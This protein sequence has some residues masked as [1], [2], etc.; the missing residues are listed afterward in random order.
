MGSGSGTRCR[1]LPVFLNLMDVIYRRLS[2]D[3]IKTL[4][5]LKNL[6]NGSQM[7]KKGHGKRRSPKPEF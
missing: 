5:R 4:D 1:V 3:E 7:R 6:F 2:L